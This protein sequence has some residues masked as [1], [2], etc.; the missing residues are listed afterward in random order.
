M[1]YRFPIIVSPAIPTSALL[2]ATRQLQPDLGDF[3]HGVCHAMKIT[4]AEN[5][6]DMG[7]FNT[8]LYFS[9]EVLTGAN[10]MADNDNVISL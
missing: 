6:Y 7:L 4:T 2:P 3:S 9:P 5:D 8:T 1:C 10:R